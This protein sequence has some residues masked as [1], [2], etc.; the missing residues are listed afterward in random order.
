VGPLELAY[1]YWGETAFIDLRDLAFNTRDG[2]HLAALSG[3]WHVAVA[4]FGG[5]RD[6]GDGLRFSPRLPPRL[7][8]LSFRIVF[9]G[10]RLAVTIEPAAATYELLA[11][12]PV[13]IHHYGEA[14]T[15]SRDGAET[16]PVPSVDA[17]PRPEGPSGRT[18]PAR[19]DE[20]ET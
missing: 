20:A 8:R 2:I 17:G 19:H 18:P 10:R 3:A 9:R 11:G 14:L 13:E 5:M 12:D 6:H 4:G 16:R 1:D 7:S 15:V